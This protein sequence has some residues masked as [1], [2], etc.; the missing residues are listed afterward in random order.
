MQKGSQGYFWYLS[1]KV[2]NEQYIAIKKE[3]KKKIL[4]FIP[5]NIETD[6]FTNTNIKRNFPLLF[7]RFQGAIIPEHNGFYSNLFLSGGGKLFLFVL[8]CI[9]LPY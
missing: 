6:K 8:S 3:K 1:R 4:S 2:H 9:C 5:K 7:K